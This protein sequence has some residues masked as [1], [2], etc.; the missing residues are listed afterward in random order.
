MEAA[1]AAVPVIRIGVLPALEHVFELS[2]VKENVFAV[3]MY[4]SVVE[5]ARYALKQL[6]GI[7]AVIAVPALSPPDLLMGTST[8]LLNHLPMEL[9]QVTET[10]LVSAP[11][12]LE[13]PTVIT[14][15]FFCTVSEK[16]ST[17]LKS[18]VGTTV[19]AGHV[20]GAAS[21]AWASWAWLAKSAASTMDRNIFESQVA[22]AAVKGLMIR[23]A[24]LWLTLRQAQKALEFF[25]SSIFSQLHKPATCELQLTSF[26]SLQHTCIPHTGEDVS[27]H[28]TCCALCNSGT[29]C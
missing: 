16:V 4:T 6:L 18:E 11:L 21:A 3:F 17:M 25:L 28:L 7:V 14:P 1:D 13:S 8:T 23:R 10:L 15:V 9:P 19:D 22:E 5:D 26:D 2:V 29:C 24:L 12:L 27:V 20:D